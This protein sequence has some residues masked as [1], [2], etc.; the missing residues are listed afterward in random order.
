MVAFTIISQRSLMRLPQPA[1]FALNLINMC[2]PAHIARS[3]VCL[4]SSGV[5]ICLSAAQP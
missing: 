5:F 1:G 2:P 4:G 3:F